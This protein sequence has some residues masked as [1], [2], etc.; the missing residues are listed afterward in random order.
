VLG[1]SDEAALGCRAATGHP[2]LF[3]SLRF[4][5]RA[6]VRAEEVKM[7]KLK[8][9]TV[10][11]AF[12]F[13]A[14][15]SQAAKNVTTP[16]PPKAEGQPAA[17]AKTTEELKAEEEARRVKA[18]EEA[19]L[20]ALHQ[21]EAARGLLTFNVGGTC[22]LTEAA[23]R[24]RATEIE[25]RCRDAAQTISDAQDANKCVTG[26]L[27]AGVLTSGA[28]AAAALASGAAIQLFEKSV[29]ESAPERTEQND[30]APTI[31]EFKQQ[32]AVVTFGVQIG[33]A[34]ATSAA[35][36]F[37]GA[38]A[39]Y[40][41]GPEEFARQE[42]E[43][44]EFKDLRV[45]VAEVLALPTSEAQ[46]KKLNSYSCVESKE[47]PKDDPPQQGNGAGSGSSLPTEKQR[48]QKIFDAGVTKEDELKLKL[49]RGAACLDGVSGYEDKS[50]KKTGVLQFR[51]LLHDGSYVTQYYFYNYDE[52]SIALGNTATSPTTNPELT[53]EVIKAFPGAF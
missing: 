1:V 26:G 44:K 37:A 45:S 52:K 29:V 2:C 40:V 35:A 15:Q 18:K 39:F 3:G 42:K 28:V 41:T 33:T 4:P 24:A 43:R 51:F 23:I 11:A 47:K 49:A 27:A 19:E 22:K 17:P 48:E 14:T 6:T 9:A 20:K 50:G 13:N 53:Q 21:K 46:E 36:A 10:V 5:V 30:D 8:T 32:M 7:R 34:V 12:L 25:T 31:N 38:Y 16:T